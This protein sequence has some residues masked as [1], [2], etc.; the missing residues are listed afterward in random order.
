MCKCAD[1]ID[2]RLKEHGGRL[3]RAIALRGNTMIARL[4]VSTEKTDPKKRKAL[5][6]V[7]AS[8]CPFCGIAVAD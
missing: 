3:T 6:V 8:F 7:A 1:D 2:A 4:L 5:P